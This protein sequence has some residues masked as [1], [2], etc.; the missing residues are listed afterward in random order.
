MHPIHLSLILKILFLILWT[1]KSETTDATNALAQFMEKLSPGTNQREANFGWN[2]SSDP[3]NDN[4]KGVTC[5]TNS[6]NI[7]KIVLDQLNLTGTLDATSLCQTKALMVLSLNSNNVAGNL[8]DDISNCSRLTHIYLHGNNFSGSLPK[9]LSGLSNL[10]RIDIS[11]NGFSGDIP[12]I[13]RISGLLSFIAQN[14]RLSGNIPKFDFSNLE[15]FNVSNNNL[16]GPIPDVG[17]RFNGTSFL[18]NPGLCG[19]PLPNSCPLTKKKGSFNKDYFIYSGYALIGL[20]VVFLVAFKL[21]IKKGKPKETKAAAKTNSTNDKVKS[22]LMVL[23]NP[24][25]DGLRFEDL[26]RSPAEL[27]GRGRKGSLYKVTVNDEGVNLAVKRIRGWDI[28]RDGF[29]KRMERIDLVKHPNVMPIVAFYCSRQEKL[30][31]YEFQDNG[32]LFKLLHESQNGQSFNWESRLNVAAKISEALAFMHEGLQ[33]DKIPHGNLKS[34]NILFSNKMEPLISEYGLALAEAENQDQSF[35]AQ[36]ENNSPGGITITPNN[37]FKADI[38]C[39]GII[40]LELLTGKLVH[41]NG[42]DLARWV[43]SAIREEWTVE[44]FDKMLVSDGASE[45]TMLLLLQL[46]L[47]CINNTS[48]SHEGGVSFREIARMINSIKESEEKSISSDP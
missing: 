3:C 31:V 38:Y 21:Y 43:N 20:I 26:L 23:S 10:K 32:S 1:A 11:D 36:I 12:N 13:S 30:L 27:I 34:S 7:K 33:A 22:S 29:K 8:P 4:W 24:V 39:F 40:L 42:F 48:S 46:A 14:N 25:V 6:A 44:V 28:S 37:A 18:G 2:L 47:K 9:S 45:E 35:L 16:T 5:Y 41:N 15:E 19:K 17:A